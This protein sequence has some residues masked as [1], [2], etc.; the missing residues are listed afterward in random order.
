[1]KIELLSQGFSKWNKKDYAKFLRA[2]EIYGLND[3]ENISK[4][5]RSK[6]VLQVEEYVNAFREKVDSLPGGTRIMAKIDKFEFEKNK[7]NEYHIILDDV[8]SQISSCYD[9]ILEGLEIPYRVKS[10][11]SSEM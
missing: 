6:T 8:F 11:G 2:C 1:L 7:I 9:N 4:S 3:Y 5:M 10:K